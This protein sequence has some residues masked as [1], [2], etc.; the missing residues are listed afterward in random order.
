MRLSSHLLASNYL[1]ASKRG[2]VACLTWSSV[3][4][5][6]NGGSIGRR[7]FLCIRA[8]GSNENDV[9][10]M[11]NCEHELYGHTVGEDAEEGPGKRQGVRTYVHQ[12]TLPLFLP[13][14]S[15]LRSHFRMRVSGITEG[16]DKPTSQR[17]MKV[18][19]LGQ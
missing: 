14:S 9:T 18:P 5:E 13:F 4:H 11:Q 6:S 17:G 19:F 16:P 15:H 8:A 3:H 10:A 1:Q 2:N 12:A 7:L